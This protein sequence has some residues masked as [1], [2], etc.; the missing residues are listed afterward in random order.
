MPFPDNFQIIAFDRSQDSETDDV[1]ETDAASIAE[2][3]ASGLRQFEKARLGLMAIAL[4]NCSAGFPA[5]PGYDWQDIVGDLEYWAAADIP[6]YT[7]FMD[8]ARSRVRG[9]V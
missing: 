1:Q 8:W 6:R 4:N 7:G 5:P 3:A 2:D 9:F